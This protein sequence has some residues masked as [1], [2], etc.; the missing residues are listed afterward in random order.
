MG[1]KLNKRPVVNRIKY[2]NQCI[3]NIDKDK[4][5]VNILN[6]GRFGPFKKKTVLPRQKPAYGP[7]V[8]VEPVKNEPMNFAQ[9]SGIVSKYEYRNSIRPI[10]ACTHFLAHFVIS[11]K[12]QHIYIAQ[13]PHVNHTSK[14]IISTFLV[15]YFINYC[16][17]P[18][19]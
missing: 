8:Y 14:V 10:E 1:P 18:M 17:D 3:I 9:S 15:L 6:Y 11:I 2:G 4:E 16:R 13:I 12:H 5:L 19:T 7:T